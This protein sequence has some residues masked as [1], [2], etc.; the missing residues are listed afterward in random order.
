MFTTIHENALYQV[1]LY[2]KGYYWISICD[3][4][5]KNNSTKDPYSTLNNTHY[6]T[7]IKITYIN[8]TISVEYILSIEWKVLIIWNYIELCKFVYIVWNMICFKL[9]NFLSDCVYL[10]ISIRDCCH[11]W[12]NEYTSFSLLFTTRFLSSRQLDVLFLALIYDVISC[13]Y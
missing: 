2:Y 11:N 1:W 4:G 10:N 9:Q 7:Y 13:V 5:R 12:L 8:I 3:N 6:H